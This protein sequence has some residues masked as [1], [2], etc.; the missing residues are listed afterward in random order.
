MFPWITRKLDGRLYEWV[1]ATPTL[2]LS[3]QTAIW[4]DT[5]QFGVFYAL[6]MSTDMTV[7]IL[8]SVG[9]MRLFALMINGSSDLFGPIVRAVCAFLSALMWGQFAYALLVIG[10]ERGAPSPGFLFWVSFTL[11]EIFVCY[12]ALI[13]VRRLT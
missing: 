8:A 4:P 12:R 13:D 5:V 1:F 6:V 3:I 7:A 10:M 9:S 11:A 2:G